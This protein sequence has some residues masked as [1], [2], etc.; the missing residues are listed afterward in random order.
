M[1]KSS[2]PLI[3]LVSVVTL[4]IELLFIRWIGTEINIFAYLQNTV[5][6]VCFLGLGLGC[7]RSKEKLKLEEALISL[8]ILVVLLSFPLTHQALGKISLLLSTMDDL[9]IWQRLTAETTLSKV[10]YVLFGLVMTYLIMTLLARVFVPL[11]QITGRLMDTYPQTLKAYSVNILGSLLGVWIFVAFGALKLPP[12]IWCVM[13]MAGLAATVWK[14][15]SK[16]V[17]HLALVGII[18]LIPLIV[19]PDQGFLLTL[20]SPYQKLA[21]KETAHPSSEFSGYLITVNNTGY[22]GMIDM[23][24]TSH[25]PETRNL[26]IKGFSQYDLP[27]LISP[28][29]KSFLIVGAGSGNDVAGAV[30]HGVQDITAVEIDPAIIA[31]GK[32]Y[33]PEKPYARSNVTII[34]DDARSFFFRT[35]KRFDIISFGLLDSHTTTAMT[36]ARLDHY[37]YTRES[38]ERAKSLLSEDGLMFL[39]FEVQKSYIADRIAGVLRQVFGHEPLAFI[40]PFT[41]YGWGGVMFIAGNLDK[42]HHAI[43]VNRSL[44]GIISEW[45]AKRSVALSYTTNLG[46]DNWPY[47]YL[48][49]PRI[50]LL[51]FFLAV[52][53]LALL[54]VEAKRLH[55]GPLKETLGQWDKT[56]WHFFFLGAAF[57]LLEVQNISKASVV[58]GNT[59]HVNAIIISS[60]L[61]M[62]LLA[63]LATYLFP[64]IKI[65]L[66][67]VLLVATCAALY[68]FDLSSL[69]SLP[70]HIKAPLTGLITTFPMFFSGIAFIRS[71][72]ATKRK[73]HAL[74]ANLFGS[75]VGA[76]LQS[77]SFI[78]GIRFLLV[79]VAL[80]YGMA[81]LARPK[82]Q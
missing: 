25:A 74:G 63:N 79:L 2:L 4:Y 15:S 59:W 67:Y 23:P 64:K 8:L 73:D 80:F 12:P 40:V 50:P 1:P 47:L 68:F 76:L 6:I 35:D 57:L 72:E 20:W 62:V 3:F 33:H 18:A 82:S 37:V 81:A 7:F 5:L 66:V 29:A 13:A 56:S 44:N 11:G 31:L 75:L 54:Y 19:S 24:K 51:Y 26:T 71:F 41:P 14:F 16:R 77:V 53:S 69:A 52:L 36:N 10:C 49:H 42:A 46:T 70:Y 39:T 28:G 58:L 30:R 55:S 9:L 21:L 34:N 78:S 32:K 60:I 43:S 27:F 61:A 48:R 65:E 38:I 45:N 22:Q 17:W